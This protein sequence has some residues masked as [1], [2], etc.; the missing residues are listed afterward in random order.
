MKERYQ[1]TLYSQM[2]PR[3]GTLTL[4]YDG[5]QVSGW[6]ELMGYRNAVQGTRTPG[7]TLHLS[8]SIHTAVST[9]PC[10]TVLKITQNQLRGETDT[11]PCR[12]RWEGRET[13]KKP[14]ESL[15]KEPKP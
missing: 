8:H 6:L 2:G 4:Q 3:E 13:G 1:V 12:M 15:S 9:F 7:G 5:N 10:Q 14:G 11:Q